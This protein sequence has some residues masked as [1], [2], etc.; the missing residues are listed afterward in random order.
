MFRAIRS[1]LSIGQSA[2]GTMR[3]SQSMFTAV[4]S[5]FSARRGTNRTVRPSKC[6]FA[7]IGPSFCVGKGALIRAVRKR[8]LVCS[9]LRPIWTNL[10]RRPRTYG[11]VV[12][13]HDAFRTDSLRTLEHPR[14]GGRRYERSTVVHPSKKSAISARGA[15]MLNLQCRWRS[16]FFL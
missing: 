7:G 14:L 11:R 6:I 12:C 1:C 15:L 10:A 8:L 5:C 2:T 13:R 3:P 4:R 16:V 9:V